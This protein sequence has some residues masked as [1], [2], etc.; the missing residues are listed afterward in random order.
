VPGQPVLVIISADPR[1]SHRAHE[2]MRIALGV[3]AG[4][5]DVAI[6]LDGPAAHLLDEDT[7]DLVD[8]D[9]IQKVRGSL[10]KMGV[11]LHIATAS[12]PSDAGWNAEGHPVVAVDA[13]RLAA[14]VAGA[15]RFM[16]F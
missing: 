3:A 8:G 12:I 2:A 4:E 5:T 6:V 1:A 15:S 10:R 11:P 14:L 9:D 13:E 16:V 7:D